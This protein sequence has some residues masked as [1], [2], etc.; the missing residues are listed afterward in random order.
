MKVT[1]SIIRVT[2]EQTENPLI[3]FPNKVIKNFRN[4]RL[5]SYFRL[6]SFSLA[7]ATLLLKNKINK[8]RNSPSTKKLELFE[9]IF[10]FSIFLFRSF[11]RCVRVASRRTER[12]L[13]IFEGERKAFP[14]YFMR[15]KI[16][17]NGHVKR[18]RR[19]YEDLSRPGSLA[20]AAGRSIMPSSFACRAASLQA[21]LE[22]DKVVNAHY[23]RPGLSQGQAARLNNTRPVLHT[24]TYTC[25]VAL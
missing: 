3:K 1:I 17:R 4:T 11:R 18:V 12:E 24:P 25:I 15:A 2:T 10:L 7:V 13:A 16:T 19:N 14:T 8:N 6:I 20:P 23:R 9:S 5:K 22:R 21:R